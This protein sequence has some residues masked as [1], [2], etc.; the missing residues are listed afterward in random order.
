[1]AS[2]RVIKVRDDLNRLIDELTEDKSDQ[3]GHVLS[4]CIA[5]AVEEIE[6][7]MYNGEFT[8]SVVPYREGKDSKPNRKPDH[9]F[10]H[11]SVDPVDLVMPSKASLP[12]SGY[13]IPPPSFTVPPSFPPSFG[14]TPSNYLTPPS[15]MPVLDR[16]KNK[17]GNKVKSY[18]FFNNLAPEDWSPEMM[19]AFREGSRVRFF[20]SVKG[21]M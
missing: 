7:W 12:V 15:S 2:D 6:K 4:C 21:L 3:E 5:V 19:R 8:P 17:A 11:P 1:M 13:M 9:R 18:S 10:P 16:L 20:D 14:P